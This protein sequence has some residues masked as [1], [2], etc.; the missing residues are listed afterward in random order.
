MNNKSNNSKQQ[1]RGE[2]KAGAKRSARYLFQASPKK[3]A[4]S[5]P[6][7]HTRPRFPLLFF[8]Y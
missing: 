5:F 8:S 7:T 6:P 1:Q 4:A 2:R 3:N